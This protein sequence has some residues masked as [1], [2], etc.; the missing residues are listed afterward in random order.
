MDCAPG[1]VHGAEEL[2]RKDAVNA[3]TTSGQQS[4]ISG[5]F[6]AEGARFR[7]TRRPHQGLGSPTIPA[8]AEA[9]SEVLNPPDGAHMG[10][11]Q[12]QRF[13]GGLLRH[14]S[15]DAA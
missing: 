9:A 14:Y 8:S 12:C 5:Q 3:T 13:L 4:A 6:L 15:R 10:T 2:E 7:Y 1:V 11:I